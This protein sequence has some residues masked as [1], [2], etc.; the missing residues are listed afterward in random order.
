MTTPYSLS[1]FRCSSIKP[2]MTSKYSSILRN[3]TDHLFRLRTMCTMIR[4]D[5]TKRVNYRVEELRQSELISRNNRLVY[6]S[7]VYSAFKQK[8]SSVILYIIKNMIIINLWKRGC[9]SAKV[10]A[11]TAS[12]PHFE[13]ILNN[14]SFC[15][16]MTIVITLYG[17]IL[18]WKKMFA[19]WHRFSKR[20]VKSKL[21]RSYYQNEGYN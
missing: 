2:A 18:Y 6:D 10:V 8:Q 14:A 20:A 17:T 13:H 16:Q 4:S 19:N 11:L 15:Y 3:E 7:N 12:W 1:W 5:L 21:M 9:H